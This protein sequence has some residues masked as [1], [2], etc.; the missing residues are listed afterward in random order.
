MS[1]NFVIRGL[2]DSGRSHL[3]AT[4]SNIRYVG[5][6]TSEKR[7]VGSLVVFPHLREPYALT[8]LPL[9]PLLDL[10]P[11]RQRMLGI[12]NSSCIRVSSFG[13]WIPN[14]RLY[15]ASGFVGRS[16]VI[17]INPSHPSLTNRNPTIKLSKPFSF[18]HIMLLL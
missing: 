17:R 2:S 7:R 18:L 1:P 9:L 11:A 14:G 6:A 4:R 12:G 15:K 3:Y 10:P 8:P 13:A 16:I 5:I